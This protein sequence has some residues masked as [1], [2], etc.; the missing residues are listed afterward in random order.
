MFA[1]VHPA[2]TVLPVFIL[3]LLVA[4]ASERTGWLARPVAAHMTYNAI[5]SGSALLG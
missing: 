3:A 2:H 1:L 4:S 5:V